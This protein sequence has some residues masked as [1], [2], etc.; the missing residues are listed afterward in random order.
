GA[1]FGHLAMLPTPLAA[2][3]PVVGATSPAAGAAGVA[4]S[5]AVTVAFS[6]PMDTAATQAAFSLRAPDGSPVAGSFAWAG[7]TL[8]FRP[9]A[10]L[11]EATSYTATITTEARDAAGNPLAAARSWT[12]RTQAT[13]AASPFAAAITAGT[14][15][16][17]DANRLRADDNAYF[18]VNS[19]RSGTRA[20]DLYGRFRGVSN[21]LRSLRVAYRG[22]SSAVCSQTVALYNWRTRAWAPLD[23]RMVGTTEVPLDR[24]VAGSLTDYVSGTTGDGEVRLRVRCTGPTSFYA[25][26]DLMR[27][28][29]T[30]P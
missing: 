7:T 4:P 11:R 19:T 6:E 17:G 14:L 13:V 1:Y 2:A 12:F 29:F 9:A 18:Q 21:G 28:T 3:P 20:A 15:R 27:I 8:T 5:S 22:K 24:T 16:A 30:R 10:P 26:A 23:T 25:S